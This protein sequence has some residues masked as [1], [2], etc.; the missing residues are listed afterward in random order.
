MEASVNLAVTAQQAQM[1]RLSVLQVFIATNICH[2]I[3]QVSVELDTTVQQAQ[4]QQQSSCA[5]QA[6][7]ASQASSNPKNVLL[8]HITL[9]LVH[10]LFPIVL[11]AQ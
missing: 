10:H 9:P 11:T 3:L 5:L 4:K 2:K 7:I 1:K 8:E 6:T